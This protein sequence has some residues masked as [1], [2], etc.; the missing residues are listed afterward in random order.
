MP[1]GFKAEFHFLGRLCSLF[2]PTVY[3]MCY[4]FPIVNLCILCILRAKI[5]PF[6]SKLLLVRYWVPPLIKVVQDIGPR[7]GVMV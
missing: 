5:N 6:S 4:T 2:L 1:G 7:S 3:N